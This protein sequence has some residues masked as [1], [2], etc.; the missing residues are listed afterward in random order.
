MRA[1]GQAPRPGRVA[2]RHPEMAGQV[3]LQRARAS[4]EV[5]PQLTRQVNAVLPTLAKQVP[6]LAL[7]LAREVERTSPLNHLNLESLARVLPEGVARLL[8]DSEDAPPRLNLTPR[9]RRLSRETTEALLRRRPGVLPGA[10]HTYGK[11]PADVRQHLAPIF[12]TTFTTS[13]GLLPLH[14]LEHLPAALR[15]QEARRHLQLPFLQTR[16]QRKL[17]YAAF[18]P[19]DEARTV[20]DAFLRSPDAEL[21]AQ[22]LSSL[23]FCVR[24]ERARQTDR[25]RSQRGAMSRTRSAS[26]CCRVCADCRRDCGRKRVWTLWVRCF[27]TP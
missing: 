23:I 22:G 6:D 9:L 14:I 1:A 13:V 24:Y 15:T 18:L 10:E 27:R 25:G 3:L 17:E 5:H 12:V 19:W 21:R 16:I 7:D 4:T 8:L 2:R 26:P 11:L 20:L